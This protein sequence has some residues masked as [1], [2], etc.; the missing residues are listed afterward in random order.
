MMNSAKKNY[1]ILVFLFF[2]ISKGESQYIIAG[3]SAA[4]DLYTDIPDHVL[5]ASDSTATYHSDWSCQC[6]Y[7]IDQLDIDIDNNGRIF[8]IASYR[9]VFCTLFLYIYPGKLFCV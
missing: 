1:L 5:N 8:F 9:F 7:Y 4:P 6:T 3:N 2:L